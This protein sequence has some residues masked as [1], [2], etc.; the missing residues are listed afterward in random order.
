MLRTLFLLLAPVL[1]VASGVGHGVSTQRWNT[2]AA[3]EQAVARLQNVPA[4]VGDWEGEVGE[5]IDSRQAEIGEIRGSLFRTYTHRRT[6]EHLTILLVCGRPGPIAV[7]TPD[8]CYRGRGYVVKGAQV[9]HQVPAEGSGEPAELVTAVFHKTNAAG[10]D[11]LR[12]YWSWYA[13]GRWQV[14]DKPRLAFAREPA[15]YK[16]YVIRSLTKPDGPVEADVAQ[17]F[18]K[19]F[20][21]AMQRC[22]TTNS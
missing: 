21:P 22:L 10:F 2:S 11:Q 6:G 3:V 18:L 17:D 20:L 12:I 8:V 19:Q 9:R 5:E 7:H 14:K 1:L 16:L 15:L 4:I 13:G